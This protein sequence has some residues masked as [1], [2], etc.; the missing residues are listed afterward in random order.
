MMLADTGLVRKVDDL[1]RVVLPSSLRTEMDMSAGT[2]LSIFVN[3][4]DGEVVLRRYDI[5][6][7]F[8]GER[9][10]LREVKGRKVCPSCIAALEGMARQQR[11]CGGLEAPSAEEIGGHNGG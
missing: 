7:C 11:I 4:R 3:R 1:G 5:A 6:C 2:R 10:G 9:A 8:C